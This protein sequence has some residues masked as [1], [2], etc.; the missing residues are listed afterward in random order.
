[1]DAELVKGGQVNK[2]IL[3]L[4]DMVKD[5]R[6]FL[7]FLEKWVQSSWRWVKEDKYKAMLRIEA[8][9]LREVRAFLDSRGFTEAL[10]PPI[11]GPPVT[12]PGIRG[13]K[14]ATIDFY[15]HEYKVM[16]SAILYKQYLAHRWIR[17]TS[18]PPQHKARAQRQR[19]DGEALS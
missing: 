2:S 4:E 9:T 11:V 5:E 19:I 3:E 7:G 15:G 1:M 8:T 14:Q 10:A 18:S 13:A 17:C 16:S 6:A 12:D